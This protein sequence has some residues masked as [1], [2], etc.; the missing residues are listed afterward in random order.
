MEYKLLEHTEINI[1]Y[2]NRQSDDYQRLIGEF[3]AQGITDYHFWEAICN[4]NSVVESI[5]ASHKMIV[6]WAKGNRKPFVV[7]AEQDLKFTALGGWDYF[8]K[9][10][11]KDYDVYIGGSYL[12]DNRNVYEP[13]LVKVNE[14]VGNHLIIVHE[15]YYDK[16]LNVSDKDH[17][18]TVHRGNGD[19]YVCYPYPALQRAGY[20]F[21]QQAIANYNSALRPEDI[22]KGYPL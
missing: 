8:L 11:P 12:I 17:I 13:P 10:T 1:I 9:N 20:S 15:K 6:R 3:A 2:D 16:F 22:W 5:N 4:K 21:N 19:F 14:W 7:I 18:D